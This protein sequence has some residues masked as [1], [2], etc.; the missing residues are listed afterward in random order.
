MKTNRI[1]ALTLLVCGCTYYENDPIKFPE[2]EVSN[3]TETLEASFTTSH[4]NKLTADYW[5]TADY[6]PILPENLITQ[7]VPDEDGLYNVSGTLDG[8]SDFNWGKD[9]KITMKAAYDNDSLYILVSWRDTTYNTSKG[10][11]L[12]NGPSDPNKAGVTTGWTS[13]RNEDHFTISFDQ[14]GGKADLWNWSSALS[15]PMGFAMDMNQNGLS[16]TSDEGNKTYLRNNAGADNRGGPQYEWDEVE[17]TLQRKP[18]GFTILDPGFY[19]L[20]KKAFTGDAFQGEIIFQA[21]CAGCHGILADGEGTINPVGIRLNVPGQF[22]RLTRTA[23]DAFASNASSHE[24]AVHYQ[25]LTNAQRDDLM[26]RLRG[27]SGVPGYYLQNPDG[28]NADV[29]AASNILLARI[30]PNN[31]PYNT[32]GYTVLLIRALNTH[33]ADDI[34]FDPALSHYAF[35]FSVSDNDELNA[36]GEEN[37]QLTFLPK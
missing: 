13:Q 33:H 8:L 10:N 5:K 37:I 21:E 20:N 3:S 14:G 18:A 34:I 30:N 15:E 4:P 12:F 35:N 1:C 23:L 11:W 2:P 24:G 17:Q 19:L 32:K 9:S 28:S 7:Q 31:S 29:H 22:N 6:L 36:I 27:F 25:P 26:A 16:I